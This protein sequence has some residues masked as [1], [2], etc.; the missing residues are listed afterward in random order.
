MK[1]FRSKMYP[2][3][4]YAY[5]TSTGWVMFP[6]QPNGWEKRQPGRGIDPIDLRQVP[7]HLAGNTGMPVSHPEA[8]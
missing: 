1:L 3:R 4:W 2:Q 8:A 5:T 7:C 6:A